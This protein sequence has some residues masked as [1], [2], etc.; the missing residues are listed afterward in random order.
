MPLSLQARS[1]SFLL[2]TA[3]NGS[4]LTVAESRARSA[5]NVR[6]MN[7][8]PPGVVFESVQL[9]DLPAAWVRPTCATPAQ[10]VLY[11]H[12][13]GYVQGGLANYR[14]LSGQLAERLQIPLLFPEYRLAPENPFPA[15]LNDALKAYRWLLGQGYA[16]GKIVLCGD[17]AG[18]G[19]ALATTLALRAAGDPLPA[20]VV[21]L[22]PWADLTLSGQ[23]HQTRAKAEAVLTTAGLRAW[24]DFYR[25]TEPAENPLISPVYADFQGF[26]PLL[27]QVGGD[28]ILLDDAR[29][30]AEKA[31]AVGVDVT[32]SLW[33]G[34]FHVWQALGDLLPE[35]GPAFSEIGQFVHQVLTSPA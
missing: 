24:A 2:R 16:P 27:I 29:A 6:W 19:L 26:P 7:R 30:V 21:C 31:Q 15:A 11:L 4:R 25:G 12:G 20:A 17:S 32:L 34:L 23:S 13:G 10:V 5:N 28:E 3:F 14:M 22:S 8:L 33:P 35:N 9:G 18:G 1:W